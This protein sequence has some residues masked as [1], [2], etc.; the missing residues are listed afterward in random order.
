MRGRLWIGV[1]NDEK[2]VLEGYEEGIVVL[3]TYTFVFT[4]S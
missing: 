1:V 2:D 4:V 3:P